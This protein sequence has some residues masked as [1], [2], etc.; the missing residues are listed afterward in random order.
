MYNEESGA[1][2]LS[3]DYCPFLGDDPFLVFLRWEMRIRVSNTNCGQNTHTTVMIG[4]ESP[5]LPSSCLLFQLGSQ[6][7][8]W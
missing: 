1:D 6:F 8:F 2:T 4:G 3:G 5:M 7:H